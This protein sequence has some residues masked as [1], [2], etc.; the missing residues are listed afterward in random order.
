M[1]N[2]NGGG[3]E[4]EVKGEN[5]EM[6]ERR[7]GV[8]TRWEGRQ[9]GGRGDSPDLTPRYGGVTRRK[10]GIIDLTYIY[11]LR[12]GRAFPTFLRREAR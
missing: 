10:P 11:I 3:D 8:V 7:P 2:E 1:G 4:R 6:V 12:K 9:R 5:R